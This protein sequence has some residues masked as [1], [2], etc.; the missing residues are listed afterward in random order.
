METND[1]NGR[2]VHALPSTCRVEKGSASE[3]QPNAMVQRSEVPSE[4]I[5]VQGPDRTK[6]TVQPAQVSNNRS[7]TENREVDTMQ[8]NGP[9]VPLTPHAGVLLFVFSCA[10]VRDCQQRVPHPFQRSR[11]H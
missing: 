5:L 3:V 9:G 1:R 2:S 7:A 11:F 10:D 6:T 8:D 4:A